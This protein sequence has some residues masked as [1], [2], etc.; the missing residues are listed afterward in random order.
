MSVETITPVELNIIE[1]FSEL[2]GDT[3]TSNH[4]LI[5]HNGRYKDQDCFRFFAT[6]GTVTL[7]DPAS[8]LAARHEIVVR[9]RYNTVIVESLT[10]VGGLGVRFRLDDHESTYTF[11]LYAYDSGIGGKLET[12]LVEPFLKLLERYYLT[13]VQL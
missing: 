8:P 12:T 13:N 2:T 6:N 11:G 7:I 5:G 3:P 1:E 9:K 10:Y 4:Y